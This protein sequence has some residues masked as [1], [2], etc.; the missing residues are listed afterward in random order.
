M[1]RSLKKFV[2]DYIT[3]ED[4]SFYIHQS[5]F[6]VLE[7][8]LESSY[9]KSLCSYLDEVYQIIKVNPHKWE[10]FK[11]FELTDFDN[12]KVV[13]IGDQPYKMTLQNT[14][15][16]LG[17]SPNSVLIPKELHKIKKCLEKTCYDS[18]VSMFDFTLESWCEEGVLLLNSAFT[19][20][21]DE[22]HT[23]NQYDIWRNFNR[24]IVKIIC[25]EKPGTQFL[26]L[27]DEAAYFE[28]YIDKKTCPVYL[29][30]HPSKAV[31][32]EKAWECPYFP[33]I[34]KVIEETLGEDHCIRW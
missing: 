15:L 11:P 24:E 9:M 5:W 32:L 31:F 10:L 7:E 6:R 12:I 29:Y 20:V 30:D 2:L 3:I 1:M 26:L 34:N 22:K 4:F 18:V 21:S 28:K 14:G 19:Q 33:I 17:T 8:F 27:G 25:K 16:P 23:V 13:I